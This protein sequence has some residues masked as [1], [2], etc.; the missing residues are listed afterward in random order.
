MSV[1]LEVSRVTE[2]H[3]VEPKLIDG[4]FAKGADVIAQKIEMPAETKPEAAAPVLAPHDG[5]ALAASSFQR[6]PEF[7]PPKSSALNEW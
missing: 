6:R 1:K 3:D 5:S 4:S 7:I 2:A